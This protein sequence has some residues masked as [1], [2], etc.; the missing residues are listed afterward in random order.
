VQIRKITTKKVSDSVVE[1][2]EEMIKSGTFQPGEKLPSVRQLCEMFGVGRSAVRDAITT[3]K[4]K[5]AVEVKQGEGTYVLEFDSTRLFNNQLL[6]PRSRDIKELFQV[7]KILEPEIA[8]MAAIHRT[9]EDLQ[10]I[11]KIFSSPSQN[12]WESDYY[13]HAAI[14]NAAGNKIMIEL[15]QFISTT[16]KNAMID[17]HHYIEKNP[18]TVQMIEKQHLEIFEAIQS[19]LPH[20]AKQMMADHLR[21]VEKEL[22]K[23]RVLSQSTGH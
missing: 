20:K 10:H 11:G 21:F 6:L 22:L 14:A 7:R 3:L 4:G 5:G 19:G 2:M 23:S 18:S 8:E 1:Q 15:I 9:E 13:L 12:G 17:F 16:M